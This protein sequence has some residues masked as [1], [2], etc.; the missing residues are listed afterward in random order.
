M[1]GGDPVR[2]THDPANDLAP[3]FST[4]GT[5]IAFRSDRDGGGIYL[6][7]ALGGQ[8]RFLAPKGNDPRISPSGQEVV[9]WTGIEGSGDPDSPEW[10]RLS[11]IDARGGSPRPLA[12]DHPGRHPIWSPDGKQ[13]LFLSLLSN[14]FRFDWCLVTVASADVRCLSAEDVIGDHQHRAASDWIEDRVLYQADAEASPEIW[15]I[16]I[17]GET[18][19][20]SGQPER[21][22]YGSGEEQTPVFGKPNQIVF[23]DVR[24]SPDI[25]SVSLNTETGRA[26]GPERQ[27]TADSAEERNL[28]ASL[29]GAKLLYSSDRS[30]TGDLWLRDLRAAADTRLT[31]GEDTRWGVLE[32]TGRRAVYVRVEESSSAGQPRGVRSLRILDLVTHKSEVICADWCGGPM[33]WSTN[34]EWLFTQ[35]GTSIKAIHVPTKKPADILMRPPYRL[36]Q[37]HLSPN[38]QWIAF[39]VKPEGNDGSIEVAPFRGEQRVAEAEWVTIAGKGTEDKPRWSADGRMIYF[40][41]ER[42]VAL[43]LG[44]PIRL[45]Y[46]QT[47]W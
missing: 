1:A 42:E 29:D 23:A 37:P 22:T 45:G 38:G 40:T 4:D 5:T 33:D 43:A 28:T 27:I 34:G 18:A 15:Q 31:T 19:R 21:V 24:R 20:L 7:S 6:V 44:P 26:E 14:P 8:E 41:S 12:K 39:L 47:R 9:Y 3:A 25:W 13:V 11:M 17:N 46:R 36:W 32:S 2:L 10:G 16:R 30:G 35:V